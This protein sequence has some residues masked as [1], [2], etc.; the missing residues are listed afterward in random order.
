MEEPRR[1][2]TSVL[3]PVWLSMSVCVCLGRVTVAVEALGSVVEREACCVAAAVWQGV[4][5]PFL[6]LLNSGIF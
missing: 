1:I 2:A 3:L 4:S 6:G 5:D